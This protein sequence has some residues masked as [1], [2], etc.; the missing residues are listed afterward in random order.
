MNLCPDLKGF[1]STLEN[2]SKELESQNT[3]HTEAAI[4]SRLIYRMKSKFRNDKGLKN[5]EKI[6]RALLNYLEIKLQKEFND[7]RNYIE[8]D[9]KMVNLPTRQMLEYVLVRI[10]GFAKLMARVES[11]AKQSAE[12]WN[13]RICIGHAW[14][15]SV[16]AYAVVSRVW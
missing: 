11:V 1:S 15:I 8:S 9:G 5:M 4:L 16:I 7:L 2:A 14:I 6:N 13:T 10:Q 3:F 12:F